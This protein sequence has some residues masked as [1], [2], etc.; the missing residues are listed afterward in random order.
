M[1]LIESIVRK[2]QAAKQRD[3]LTHFSRLG[4]VRDSA[5]QAGVSRALVYWWREHSPSFAEKLSATADEIFGESERKPTQYSPTSAQGG[6][7][8]KRERITTP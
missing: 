2:R 8:R 3:F 6:P 4:N 1:D 5:K 7:V